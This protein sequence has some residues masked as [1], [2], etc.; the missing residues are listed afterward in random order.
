M[1]IEL[2]NRALHIES[3]STTLI[4]LNM[5]LETQNDLKADIQM[6]KRL[7]SELQ[8]TVNQL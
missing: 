6:N 3:I 4:S 8:A 7:G 5:K 1:Q 2:Q